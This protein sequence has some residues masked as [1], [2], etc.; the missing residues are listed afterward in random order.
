MAHHDGA[1]VTDPAR[2]CC[3]GPVV[4]SAR[5][6]SFFSR[7]FAHARSRD[8]EG[9]SV[10]CGAVSVSW[11]SRRLHSR[12]GRSQDLRALQA[13]FHRAYGA[14]VVRASH[15][16]IEA[17]STRPRPRAA[18][19]RSRWQCAVAAGVRAAVLYRHPRRRPCADRQPWRLAR[20]RI[21]CRPV[22]R[23]A[24]WS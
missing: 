15:R 17:A 24:A 6:P 7:I 3:S 23:A 8:R 19:G 2:R 5:R 20:A 11:T 4:S 13:R 22:A 12:P 21:V 10:F 14:R 1:A 18:V 16:F 9:R